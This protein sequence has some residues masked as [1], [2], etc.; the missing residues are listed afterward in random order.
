MG[1]TLPPETPAELSFANSELRSGYYGLR[2]YN[3]ILLD[4]YMGLWHETDSLPKD[5]ADVDVDLSQSLEVFK[6]QALEP[7]L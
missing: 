6:H 4:P 2:P 7:N 3:D 1:R 5:H